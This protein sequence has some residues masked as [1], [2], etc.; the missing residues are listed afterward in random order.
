MLVPVREYASASEMLENLFAIR[1]GF[2]TYAPPSAP[3]VSKPKLVPA[4]KPTVTRPWRP[5]APFGAYLFGD[6]RGANDNEDL[7]L[8]QRRVT[9]SDILRVVSRVW[10]V[11]VSA[12]TGGR[13]THDV[14]RPRQAVYVLSCRLTMAS[15]PQIG[16]AI[17]GRDHT[18]ILH[19]RKK[20]QP[21]LDAVE[22]GIRPDASVR[23]WAEEMFKEMNSG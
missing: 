23:E 8:S 1:R 20:M 21:V 4:S 11:H 18:S 3:M 10:G 17:G 15:M 7:S 16:R 9:V 19:G 6:K 22:A 12:I 13:R 5:C 2:R 14:M